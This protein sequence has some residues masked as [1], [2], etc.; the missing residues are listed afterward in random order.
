MVGLGF[1]LSFLIKI[2]LGHAIIIIF[3]QSPINRET[4]HL[5]RKPWMI[6]Y[7]LFYM[8]SQVLFFYSLK[9]LI[10]LFP[11]T[12]SVMQVIASITIATTSD[13]R[14][15][16]NARFTDKASVV[17]PADATAALLLI[18]AVS[19]SLY[20]CRNNF[21]QCLMFFDLITNE[22]SNNNDDRLNEEAVVLKFPKCYS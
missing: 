12:C 11:D 5:L 7:L 16:R 17:L 4:C 14:M 19:I 9:P 15:A 22:H 18:P 10:S 8:F 21:C 2:R 3:E 20:F 6:N 13:R 1:I